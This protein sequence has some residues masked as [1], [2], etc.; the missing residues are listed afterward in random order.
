MRSQLSIDGCRCKCRRRWNGMNLQRLMVSSAIIAILLTIS[1]SNLFR[2]VHANKKTIRSFIGGRRSSSK[3]GHQA[4]ESGLTLGELD[5]MMQQKN[6]ESGASKL[7]PDILFGS[8]DAPTNSAKR[9]QQQTEGDPSLSNANSNQLRKRLG[10]INLNLSGRIMCHIISPRRRQHENEDDT[11]HAQQQFSS[12]PLMS[13]PLKQQHKDH[14]TNNIQRFIPNIFLGMNYDL[15]EVWYGATRWIAR[16]SWGPL[17]SSSSHPSRGRGNTAAT[18]EQQ[19]ANQAMQSVRRIYEKL[20]PSSSLLKQSSSWSIDV[21]GEQSVFDTSDSTFRLRLIQSPSS[22]SSSF[23]RSNNSNMLS[24]KQ[25]SIEYDSAKYAPDMKR[26]CIQY[27][28]TVTLDA[29]TPFLHPRLELHSKKICVVQSGGDS[30]GNYYGGNYYGSQSSVDRR[31]ESIKERYRGRIPRSSVDSL[32]T[33][34][35]SQAQPAIITR[36]SRWLEND[37]WM[38]RKVTTDLRGNLVS[39]SEIGPLANNRADSSNKQRILPPIH[40]TGVRLRISKRIDWT[41]LGIFPW[42][43]NSINMNQDSGNG[44]LYDALQSTHVRLELC[45]VYPNEERFASIGINADLLDWQSTFKVTVGQEDVS[46]LR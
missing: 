13:L 44:G 38:P 31:M 41:T 1:P 43:R 26:D 46:I 24:S 3:H 28:P 4:D 30:N 18:P 36:L 7:G 37:G 23:Q 5:Q 34:G 25:F 27:A 15:D 21:E 45:G 14:Y 33:N 12:V 8:T 22:S 17:F 42:S 16:C 40:N 11:S 35:A 10:R 6:N 20:L 32:S 9:H 2:G 29:K 39:I 19:F